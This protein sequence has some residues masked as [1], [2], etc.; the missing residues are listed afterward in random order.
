MEASIY[1]IVSTRFGFGA[2]VARGGK[3]IASFLPQEDKQALEQLLRASGYVPGPKD[4][5]LMDAGAQ[6]RE[7][8]SGKR[9]AFDLPVSFDHRTGFAQKIY[10]S[11]LKVPYGHTVTYGELA[12]AVGA[13]RGARAVGRLMAT[14]EL[15]PIVPCHRVLCASGKLGGFSAVQGVALKEQML[16]MEK[17]YVIRK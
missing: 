11:L 5:L 1:K 16:S 8:F 15:A 12:G 14:N 4:R 7:Y 9:T 17:K 6:V 10:K 3:I 2:V 13:P